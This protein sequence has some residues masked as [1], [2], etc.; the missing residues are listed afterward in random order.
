VT[1]N[2]TSV[3]CS[4]LEE[5]ENYSLEIFDVVVGA[6]SQQQKKENPA[7]CDMMKVVIANCPNHL[8]PFIERQVGS[9]A[10]IRACALFLALYAEPQTY[11]FMAAS[12]S[13]GGFP[14]RERADARRPPF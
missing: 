2:L 10:C 5:T 1:E 7:G 13:E 6:L 14:N 11:I 8:Q 4:V 9:K 12:P 3:L